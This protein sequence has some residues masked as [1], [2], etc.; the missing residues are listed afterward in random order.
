L[1]FVLCCVFGPVHASVSPTLS[2]WP[3][4]SHC[5]FCFVVCVVLLHMQVSS[6]AGELS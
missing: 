2:L 4:P 3:L 1:L 6:V 5:L